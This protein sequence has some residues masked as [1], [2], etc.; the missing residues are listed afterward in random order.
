MTTTTTTLPRDGHP[1]GMCQ[2]PD[3]QVRARASRRTYTAQYK[4]AVLTEY[5]VAD[6]AGKGAILRREGL[7]TSLITAWRTQRDHG[8]MQAL[9]RSPGAPKASPDS[10]EV[11]RLRKENARLRADLDKSRAVIEVQGKLSALLDTLASDSSS[12]PRE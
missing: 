4:T 8:G 9:G 11:V 6:K 12:D 5:E 10:R 7:Y 1:G 2:I 3:P